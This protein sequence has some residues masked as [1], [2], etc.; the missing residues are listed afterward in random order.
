MLQGP[1][2]LPWDIHLGAYGP[3]R[4]WSSR[5]LPSLCCCGAC[6]GLCPL[7][8]GCLCLLGCFGQD[9]GDSFD[10]P[11]CPQCPGQ[12]LALERPQE[13]LFDGTELTV[14][15]SPRAGRHKR[16]GAWAVGEWTEEA[17]RCI[18]VTLGSF[19][20]FLSLRLSS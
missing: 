6:P 13:G 17:W 10:S 15:A 12:G 19:I 9:A 3:E 2:R 16:A 8:C 4:R 7:T 5:S 14:L 1:L 20:L 11:L 18:R